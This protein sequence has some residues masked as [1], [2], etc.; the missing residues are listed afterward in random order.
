MMANS[1]LE[2]WTSEK[3]EKSGPHVPSSFLEKLSGKNM[4]PSWSGI[5]GEM[6]EAKITYYSSLGIRVER[7]NSVSKNT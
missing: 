6:K 2:C 7:N 1:Q 5:S 3:K 4:S